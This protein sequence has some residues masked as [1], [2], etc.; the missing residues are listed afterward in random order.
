MKNIFFSFI[1]LI[2][3]LGIG[4]EIGSAGRWLKN[5][6]HRDMTAQHK[7]QTN[8]NYRWEITYDAGYA[9]VFIR[10]PEMGRFTIS[11]GDQEISNSNGMFRFFDVPSHNQ[12]LS[13]WQGAHLVYRVTIAPQNNTRWVLDFFSQRGLFLLEEIN[14]NNVREIHYGRRWNDLWNH[15][16]GMSTMHHSGFASFL[17]MYQNQPFDDDKLRF[18]RMQKNTTAFTTEQIGQLM[19]ALSFDDNR[20]TLAKE[21]YETVLDPENYYLLHDKFSF[22]SG[23]KK[24]ADFLQ[25]RTRHR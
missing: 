19:E 18:F 12:Q 9:E 2:P 16:Y 6:T 21:A 1:F 22:R 14:L 24:L 20:F 13:I 7:A 5:E 17:K 10:I 3:L 15:S 11:L 25:E 4:Q 23:S 8:Y